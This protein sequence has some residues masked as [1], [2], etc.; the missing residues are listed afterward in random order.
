MGTATVSEKNSTS[1]HST[2]SY[3]PAADT[4]L[5]RQH[6]DDAFR[7]IA[8]AVTGLEK[9]PINTDVENF[10]VTFFG[11]KPSEMKP[12]RNNDIRRK[13]EVMLGCELTDFLTFE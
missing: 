2:S 5:I 12:N 1:A 9:S 7:L 6:I 8:N 11:R 13:Y 4:A 3:P 10:Y